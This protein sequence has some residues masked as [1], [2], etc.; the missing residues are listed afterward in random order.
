MHKTIARLAAAA[1]LL[2]GLQLGLRPALAQAAPASATAGT[3]APA[4]EYFGRLRMSVLGIR[5][6][7]AELRAAARTQNDARSLM[8]STAL[9]ENAIVDWESKY[10]GDPWLPRSI[11]GLYTVY[12][13]IGTPDAAVQARHDTRWLLRRYA[14]SQYARDVADAP[15]RQAASPYR[16]GTGQA[17][18]RQAASTTRQATPELQP[19]PLPG[20]IAVL[21]SPTARFAAA[22]DPNSPF[23]LLQG[24]PVGPQAREVGSGAVVGVV[25]DYRTHR[26][27]A[28][29]VVLI[30]PQRS[31]DMSPV[32]G[33]GAQTTVTGPDGS[34]AVTNLARSFGPLSFGGARYADPE[35]VAVYP[36]RGSGYVGFHGI[37][38][39]APGTTSSMKLVALVAPSAGDYRWLARVNGLRARFAKPPLHFDSGL[40]VAAQHWANTMAS[41]GIYQHHCPA[42]L[43]GCRTARQYEIAGSMLLSGQN[44]AARQPPTT[45]QAI[46]SGIDAEIRN[47]PAGGWQICPYREDTGH[48]INLLSASHWIGLAVA[49]D[50]KSFD[51]GI[52]GDTMDYFDEELL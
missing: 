44:I 26:P 2:L 38:D 17:T 42:A 1:S 39:V 10:P 29:A 47:C 8:H 22:S 28:G 3:S 16:P 49:V 41:R 52:Y 11:Y 31:A 19:L 9:V 24:A 30:S 51:A 4:D 43:A 40:I 33:S 46:E 32:D 14:S 25:V 48:V 45:W 5:N 13:A 35:F 6:E 7:L 23:D 12:S 18:I 37:V 20:A 27:I 34:F 50:G 15:A 36:P 21:A